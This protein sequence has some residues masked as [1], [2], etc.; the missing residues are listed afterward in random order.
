MAKAVTWLISIVS[1]PTLSYV[2]LS[3]PKVGLYCS[4]AESSV[5][6]GWWQVVQT[7]N[8][9]IMLN[10]VSLF[11]GCVVVK[12]WFLTSCIFN[13]RGRV[14]TKYFFGNFHENLYPP[15][16][17]ESQQYKVKENWIYIYCQAMPKQQ[18]ICQ[19]SLAVF[20]IS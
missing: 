14:Q 20:S 1:K 11:L 15:P 8:H 10:C 16:F 2:A 3:H 6:C 7:N 4:K 19:L 17:V 12:L 18:H 13:V 5:P 9:H